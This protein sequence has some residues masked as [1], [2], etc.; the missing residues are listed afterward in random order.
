MQNAPLN[1]P[2]LIVSFLK[3]IGSIRAISHQVIGEFVSKE[4]YLEIAGQAA[5]LERAK[6]FKSAA[7][8]W[9]EA[10]TFAL[11]STNRV[12]CENRAERCRFMDEKKR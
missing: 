8:L 5:N 2:V 10:Q 1:K 11:A 4:K 3:V 12:W 6:E 7:I 9:I